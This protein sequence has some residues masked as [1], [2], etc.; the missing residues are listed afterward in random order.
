VTQRTATTL[1]LIARDPVTGQLRNRALLDAGLRATLLA[2]LILSGRLV[3]DGLAPF[4]NEAPPSGDRILD[5]LRDG[6]ARR[7]GV[8]WPR[9]YT[10][11]RVDRDALTREL[12]DSGRWRAG[13]KGRRLA[14]LDTASGATLEI[15]E[16]IRA[17][18]AGYGQVR[19]AQDAVLAVVAGMCGALGDRPRY[20]A[21]RRELRPL[22][23]AIADIE[24]RRMVNNSLVGAS[25][26]MRRRRRR[27]VND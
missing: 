11:A 23:D 26:A 3:S 4:V 14:F 19:D 2:D 9:W 22:L 24:Q 17:V 1:I 27:W 13:G 6:I 10:H 5:G 25:I 21:F 20:R 16:H 12:V 15:A 18:L 8:S 7:E